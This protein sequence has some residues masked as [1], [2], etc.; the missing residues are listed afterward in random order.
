VEHGAGGVVAPPGGQP[1]GRPDLA[2]GPRADAD[3]PAGDQDLERREDL[4]AEEKVESEGLLNAICYV[5]R[6]VQSQAQ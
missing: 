1:G 2:D 6:Q 5:H 4:G 3:D